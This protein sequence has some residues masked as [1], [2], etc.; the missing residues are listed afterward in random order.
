MNTHSI[1]W[2]LSNLAGHDHLGNEISVRELVIAL[3]GCE[4]LLR[5][6]NLSDSMRDSL[7]KQAAEN[8]RIKMQSE[9]QHRTIGE[10][11]SA[12]N[13]A[14]VRISN[15]LSEHAEIQQNAAYSALAVYANP[16]NWAKPRNQHGDL[17]TEQRS[18][19]TKGFHGFEI[20]AQTL[21]QNKEQ[22]A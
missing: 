21:Q 3:E 4:E 2:Q 15:L 1:D 19:F 9:H 7:T 8:Y 12:L 17:Q 5:V 6:V 14:N 11:E 20:A 18:V 10:L 22:A 13:N 16:R